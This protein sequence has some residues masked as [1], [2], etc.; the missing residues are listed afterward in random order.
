MIYASRPMDTGASS[1]LIDSVFSF[2]EFAGIRP[3]CLQ[4]A[5]FLKQKRNLRDK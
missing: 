4:G 5:T 1:F 3:A 2:A